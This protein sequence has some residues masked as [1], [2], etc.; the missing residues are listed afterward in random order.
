MN[1]IV[2]VDT[3]AVAFDPAVVASLPNPHIVIAA[4]G[5]LDH[6]LAAGLIPAALV[7]DLHEGTDGTELVHCFAALQVTIS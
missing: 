4:D 7:G 3:G 5:A 2:I 1:D 6:A